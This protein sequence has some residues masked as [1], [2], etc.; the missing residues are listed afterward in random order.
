MLFISSKLPLLNFVCSLRK[1]R[2]LRL[3]LWH[4]L[5]TVE[6]LRFRRC[7][8]RHLA[9]KH[10][11]QNIM[12]TFVRFARVLSKCT[13]QTCKT[14]PVKAL[15]RYQTFR[16]FS[17]VTTLCSGNVSS[18]PSRAK[19]CKVNWPRNNF[20]SNLAND[21]QVGGVYCGKR[22]LPT[23]CQCIWYKYL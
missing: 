6:C 16:H 15:P 9:S 12:A 3:A 23:C 19:L 18:L 21:K 10:H 2:S 8:W 13:L 1:V 17:R 20:I 14:A 7:R 4:A 22:P 5:G 11:W